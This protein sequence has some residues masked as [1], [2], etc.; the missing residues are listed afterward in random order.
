MHC[1]LPACVELCNIMLLKHSTA[2]VKGTHAVQVHKA[3]GLDFECL[4]ESH[5]ES[6]K[7]VETYPYEA[8]SVTTLCFFCTSSQCQCLTFCTVPICMIMTDD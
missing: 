1:T 4:Q 3:G 5:F 7:V 2:G 6:P 8:L